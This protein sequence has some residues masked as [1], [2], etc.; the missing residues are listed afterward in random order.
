MLTFQRQ[1]TDCFI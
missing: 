1:G